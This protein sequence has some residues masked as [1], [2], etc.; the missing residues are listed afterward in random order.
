MMISNSMKS[1]NSCVNTEHA[2]N[3]LSVC[4]PASLFQLDRDAKFG[5]D[6]FEFFKESANN[7]PKLRAPI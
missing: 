2:S 5:D 6:G 7:R 1:P 3:D 4:S